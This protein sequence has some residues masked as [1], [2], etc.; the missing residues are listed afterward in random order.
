MKLYEDQNLE[1]KIEESFSF[2]IVPVGETVQKI[3]YLKN[4]SDPK[5]TGKLIEL[6]FL[7]QCLDPEN[8]TLITDENI[9]VLDAPQ[10]MEAY[11]VMPVLLEWTPAID[12][13]QGLRAKLTIKGKKIIG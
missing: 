11:A 8:G 1:T 13:E 3:I 12:L 10:D 9:D 7:V 2:G 6:E 5:P 4:D